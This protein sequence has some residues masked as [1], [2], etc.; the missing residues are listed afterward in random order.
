[1]ITIL[2]SYV[3]I[4]ISRKYNNKYIL[5]ILLMIITYD[6]NAWRLHSVKITRFVS[7]IVYVT[8]YNPNQEKEIN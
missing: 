6:Y 5:I 3:Y 1:M 7:R 4:Y 2:D 8:D